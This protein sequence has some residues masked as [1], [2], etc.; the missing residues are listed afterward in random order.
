M[1]RTKSIAPRMCE[2][3]N[4]NSHLSYNCRNN[5]PVIIALVKGEMPNLKTIDKGTLKRM[6]MYIRQTHRRVENG[7][8]RKAEFSGSSLTATELLDFSYPRNF[9]DT[10]WI[11]K[12]SNACVY[13]D[14]PKDKST[15]LKN[16]L[17]N[18]TQATKKSLIDYLSMHYKDQRR[19]R[20]GLKVSSLQQDNIREEE[21]C[22]ICMEQFGVNTR[23]V[24][25]NCGHMFCT[26]CYTQAILSSRIPNCPMCRSNL[27]SEGT[28]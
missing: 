27:M 15:A 28:R 18:L 25:S 6:V 5:M 9:T 20:F 21:V 3:C 24:A 4:S 8:R 2:F 7:L 17:G 10:R 1:S 12:K 11:D 16:L 19:E 23:T 13:Y 22:A 26:G 14:L